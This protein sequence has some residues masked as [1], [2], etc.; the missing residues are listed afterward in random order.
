MSGPPQEAT[1]KRAR[2]GLFDDAS[3]WADR[4]GL[5][6]AVTTLAVVS[7]ALVDFRRPFGSTDSAVSTAGLVVMTVLVSATLLLALRASGIRRRWIILADWLVGAG[8]A[9]TIVVA[10]AGAFTGGEPATYASAGPSPLW[11]SLGL[12][13]PVVVIRRL[14]HHHRATAATLL[15]AVSAYLLIA[16]A[17]TFAFLALDRFT[18]FFGTEEP[19]TTAMYYSLVTITTLG[20]GDVT[21]A[22]DLGRLLS[23]MEALVGQVYLVTFVAMIV[24]LLAQSRHSTRD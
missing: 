20:Y 5:L 14:I 7:L 13:A 10:V 8:V 12:I 19:T 24:G 21:A 4:F 23:T 2:P 1:R 11:V 3:P 16:V 17:F 22:T 9:A 15:G 18:P 6:L